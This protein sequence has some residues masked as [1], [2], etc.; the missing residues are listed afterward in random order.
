MLAL[1]LACSSMTMI[2]AMYQTNVVSLI[3]QG[4]GGAFT[5]RRYAA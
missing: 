3:R 1:K 2:F 4:T 5:R